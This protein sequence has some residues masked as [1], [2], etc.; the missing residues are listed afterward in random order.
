[1]ISNQKIPDQLAQVKQL[2]LL[3]DNIE[4]I[5]D[6]YLPPPDSPNYDSKRVLAKI[7]DNLIIP[8]QSVANYKPSISDQVKVGFYSTDRFTQTDES[9]IISLKT[10]TETLESL[11]NGLATVKYDLKFSK[12]S[13]KHQFESE[14]HNKS[15]E[16]YGKMNEKLKQVKL[17]QDESLERIRQAYR[18]QLANAL[19][20]VGQFTQERSKL[21]IKQ[22]KVDK[23]SKKDEYTN[24]IKEL[25]KNVFDL[26]AKVEILL[27]KLHYANENSKADHEALLN[28][29]KEEKEHAVEEILNLSKKIGRLE[30][31]VTIKEEE[32]DK[33]LAEV[34]NI[35]LQLE[36]E[37]ILNEQ[38]HRDINELQMRNEN[39]KQKIKKDFEKQ[40]VQMETKLQDK[41]KESRAQILN[42]AK[43]ELSQQELDTQRKKKEFDEQEKALKE[44]LILAET[45]QKE[46]EKEVESISKTSKKEDIELISKL[47]KNEEYLKSDIQRLKREIQRTNETWEKKI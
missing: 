45:I 32:T 1:M 31:A 28:K 7:S 24:K 23:N 5:I 14:L 21:A 43:Q 25:Q 36:K 35:Q 2:G 37:K 15:L 6:S 19:T 20:Q 3:N 17:Q 8:N 29:I 4:N 27:E 46:K 22:A 40:K 26:E 41:I 10:A 47:K 18:S 38:L 39:E 42:A 16:I 9:E 33:L 34:A 13:F 30:E 11:C 44:K 12:D